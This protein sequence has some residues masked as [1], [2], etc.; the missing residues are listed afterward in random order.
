MGPPDGRDIGQAT[1]GQYFWF[2]LRMLGD[3]L[4]KTKSRAKEGE[5]KKTKH[6]GS[7]T[8][9]V[10]ANRLTV[11]FSLPAPPGLFPSTPRGPRRDAAGNQGLPQAL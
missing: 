8:V 6:N 1:G 10:P 7:D 3:R 4:S 5:G 11:L 9:Y 2:S